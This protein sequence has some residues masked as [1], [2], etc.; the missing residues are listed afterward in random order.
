MMRMRCPIK[1]GAEGGV[2]GG[3][4][5]EGGAE[6][7]GAVAVGVEPVDCGTASLSARRL[8][9]KSSSEAATASRRALCS[10]V[11]VPL[12]WATMV[13]RRCELQLSRSAVNVDVSCL[14]GYAG[15]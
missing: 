7:E 6:E 5:T 15:R 8:R 2:V 1:K 3:V 10:A 13:D 11:V 4:S 12:G 9:A 14:R